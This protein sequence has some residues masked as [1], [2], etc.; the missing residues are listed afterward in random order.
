[1]AWPPIHSPKIN[2]ASGAVRDPRSQA[3]D[4][5]RGSPESTSLLRASCLQDPERLGLIPRDTYADILRQLS[6]SVMESGTRRI[7]NQAVQCSQC[8]ST[9]GFVDERAE[10]WRIYK[11]GVAAEI[12]NQVQ[13]SQSLE[14]WISAQLLSMIENQGV[15]KFVVTDQADDSEASEKGYLVSGLTRPSLPLH[16]GCCL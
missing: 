3:V 16:S 1:M 7:S 2:W 9:V 15:R 14:R 12:G 4:G 10:G 6:P 5:L 11:W 8:D 13:S